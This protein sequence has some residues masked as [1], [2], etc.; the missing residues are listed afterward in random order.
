LFYVIRRKFLYKKGS[1]NGELLKV[2][3]G[4]WGIFTKNTFGVLH[5]KHRNNGG[6]GL[7]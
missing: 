7:G 2:N 5:S 6:I 3:A 4:S 1:L